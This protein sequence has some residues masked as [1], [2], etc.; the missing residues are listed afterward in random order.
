MRTFYKVEVIA[1][2]DKEVDNE[3]FRTTRTTIPADVAEFVSEAGT[4]FD[5]VADAIAAARHIVRMPG[6]YKE[7]EDG[8]VRI[9]VCVKRLVYRTEGDRGF[10]STSN[11]Y[12]FC[13]LAFIFRDSSSA[14]NIDLYKKSR[15]YQPLDFSF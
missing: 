8:L 5:S 4:E 14:A 7:D 12:N 9:A 13:G 6:A 15:F 3:M 10:S 1:S 2:K 11:T